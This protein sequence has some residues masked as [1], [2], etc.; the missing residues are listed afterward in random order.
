VGVLGVGVLGVGMEHVARDMQYCERS[1]PLKWRVQIERLKAP[2]MHQWL[3][4]QRPSG[5]PSQGHQLNLIL[6]CFLAAMAGDVNLFWNDF[7]EP[8]TAELEIMVAEPRSRGKGLAQEALG[9]FMAYA[10]SSLVGSSSS[11]AV[12]QLRPPGGG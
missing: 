12:V 7:E 8:N 3:P 10:V 2:C 9:L 6:I 5:Q 11:N 4:L 1:Y